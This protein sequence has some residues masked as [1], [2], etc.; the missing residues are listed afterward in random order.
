[1]RSPAR[2]LGEAGGT[3]GLGDDGDG[4]ARDGTTGA[5]LRPPTR[6]K[7]A[8]G[9]ETVASKGLESGGN[10]GSVPTVAEGR[11]SGAETCDSSRAILRSWT[12]RITPSAAITTATII[13]RTV[14]RTR[15]S[16]MGGLMESSESSDS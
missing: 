7:W 2:S 16:R 3:S 5:A 14:N 1:L 9:P 11:A 15:G 4:K 10:G 6:L 8:G 13:D 12:I